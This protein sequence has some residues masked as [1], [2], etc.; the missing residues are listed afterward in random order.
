MQKRLLTLALAVSF[1]F[2]TLC[3][4]LF[5]ITQNES[6]LAL[7][8]QQSS[9]AVT[10][11]ETRGQIYDRDLTPMTEKNIPAAVVFPSGQNM[12][13][14]R[15]WY[16]SASAQGKEDAGDLT[17][18][19]VTTN[20]AG[21]AGLPQVKTFL[22]PVR[23]FSAAPHIL[24][25]L[26]DGA[27]VSGIE[28]AYDALLTENTQTAK[29]RVMQNGIGELL[30]GAEVT[31]AIPQADKS[32]VVLTLDKRLQRIVLHA[33]KEIKKGAVV[34]I[35]AESG[36]ILALASFPGFAD[37]AQ[38]L[39]S[40]DAPLYNR[41]LAAYP[42]GSVFKPMIAAAALEQGFS[43]D[44]GF[45][46][47]GSIAVGKVAF[48]CHKR[49]GHGMLNMTG[50][51][52]ES[53]NPYFIALSQSYPA[54]I[55]LT[56]A[57]RF[58]FGAEITLSTGIKSASGTLPKTLSPAALANFSFGQGEL[59]AT[60][61]QI[62]AAYAALANGGIYRAPTLICG[63]TEDGVQITPVAGALP[64]R[65]IKEETSAAL[66]KML[67]TAVMESDSANARPSRGVI[68]GKTGTAQTG[69]Y[70]ESGAERITAWFAG[71]FA[72]EGRTVAVTV[73]VE[74]AVSGNE[75]AAPIAR[76]IFTLAGG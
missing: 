1:G 46:C 31:L 41:A 53:C 66:R 28:G 62:C 56:M 35:D 72:Y 50:A 76:E 61:L 17:A 33:G 4:Q 30:S 22:L 25:Y 13:A 60:P 43:P 5:A 68:C 71:W 3:L 10:L 6:Y 59:T 51:I 9:K 14:L 65:I 44:M 64:E 39:K 74:D 52:K 24:G 48:R 15:A 47:S 69:Q 58:G 21:L 2:L 36:E 40:E 45:S 26:S 75:S 73:T 27:G 38:A 37:P 63:T 29:A 70:D 67:Y 32:G 55:F 54:K 49:D 16:A 34:C 19:F 23:D 42:V 12:G 11:Y 20:L 7:S 18:P 57:E 8:A